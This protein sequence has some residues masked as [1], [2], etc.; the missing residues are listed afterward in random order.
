[1]CLGEAVTVKHTRLLPQAPRSNALLTHTA[2][3][4]ERCIYKVANKTP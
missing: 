3:L 1:M 4:I 2:R